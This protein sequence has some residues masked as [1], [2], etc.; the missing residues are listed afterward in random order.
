MGVESTVPSITSYSRPASVLTPNANSLP[1]SD[2][3]TRHAVDPI[4]FTNAAPLT[5]GRSYTSKRRVV[6]DSRA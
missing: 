3:S 5:S 2:T 4:R 6:K 1:S